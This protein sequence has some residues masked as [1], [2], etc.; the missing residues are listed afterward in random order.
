MLDLVKYYTHS[1]AALP[2]DPWTSHAFTVKDLEACAKHQGVQFRHGDI[3][4]IRA[5][6]IQRYYASSQEEKDKLAVTEE[7]LWVTIA[8]SLESWLTVK[9]SAGIEQ[10]E[11]MK[12]FLW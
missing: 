2:Y 9:R 1:G 12:R 4:L 8:N 7:T 3:L 10:S 5:G 11:D 6:F